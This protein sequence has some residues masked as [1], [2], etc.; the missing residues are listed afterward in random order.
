VDEFNTGC[1]KSGRQYLSLKLDSK[2]PNHLTWTVKMWH[3]GRDA[4]TGY[5]GEKFYFTWE[6]RNVFHHHIYSKMYGKKKTMKARKEVQE[7]HPTSHWKRHSWT[8][9]KNDN[10][11]YTFIAA[12]TAGI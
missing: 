7:Y 8:K 2:I 10:S 11:D 12:A 5:S 1:L 4:L 3:F 6:D 9:L